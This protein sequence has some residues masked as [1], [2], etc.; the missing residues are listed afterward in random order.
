MNRKIREAAI[1]ITCLLIYFFTVLTPLS[2]HV[3]CVGADGHV[4]F[5]AAINGRCKCA[6]ANARAQSKVAFTAVAS[7]I[8]PCGSCLDI[9]IFASNGDQQVVVPAKP[10]PPDFSVSTTALTAIQPIITVVVPTNN[11]LPD[12]PPRINPTLISLR[13]V[14]LLI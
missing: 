4:Q 9:P 10:T 7:S 5:E 8:D 11:P 14:T 13:T 12:Y 2:S 6:E 3:L 1:P